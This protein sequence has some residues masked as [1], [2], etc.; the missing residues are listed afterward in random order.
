MFSNNVVDFSTMMQLPYNTAYS[1]PPALT[2]CTSSSTSSDSS[3]SSNANSD[4][5]S[6][7]KKKSKAPKKIKT[8]L[9]MDFQPGAY[10]VLC[11][12]SR[13]CFE[14]EGNRRFRALC[15]LHKQDYQ[16]APGKLEKSRIVT[17]IMKAIRQASPVGAFVA[18]EN[19]RY[20]EV[21]QR[22][23][24]EKVGGFFRDSLHTVYRSSAKA[25]LARK[26]TDS[27]SA[28][29]IATVCSIAQVAQVQAAPRDDIFDI[30]LLDISPISVESHED[31]NMNCFISLLG[32]HFFDIESV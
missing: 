29:P 8:P 18:F 20:Y 1:M 13:E 31:E 23:A 16:D 6:V 3:V 21:S 17:K 19:G 15:E 28:S 11:G 24:R 30:S 12:R 7:L 32:G 26:R 14:W 4:S 9:P 2:A 5:S 10:T 25:K 22:T 27:V